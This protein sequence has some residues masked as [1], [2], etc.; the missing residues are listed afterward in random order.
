MIAS[1]DEVKEAV[2]REYSGSVAAV[3][4][5]PQTKCDT[6]H[7]DF[8]DGTE[9]FAKVGKPF[10]EDTYAAQIDI[11]SML[12]ERGISIPSVVPTATG[13]KYVSL[14]G[15]R[16]LEMHA[17]VPNGRPYNPTVE[18]V[19]QVARVMAEM[20]TAAD[21]LDREHSAMKIMSSHPYTGMPKGQALPDSAML[22][23]FESKLSDVPATLRPYVVAA[24]PLMR[25]SLVTEIPSR[26]WGI[27]HADLN[28][29]QTMFDKDTNQFK[30]LIDWEWMLFGPRARDISYS[31]STLTIGEKTSAESK[32]PISKPL[33]QSFID[34]YM[35]TR[36]N[37]SPEDLQAAFQHLGW[38][39][40]CRRTRWINQVL[41]G[42]SEERIAQLKEW[43]DPEP[44]ERARE[45]KDLL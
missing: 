8:K 18:D 1:V 34:T 42:V 27:I 33:V 36:S 44:F 17:W 16:F 9:R 31:L 45:L 40:T 4:K 39:A 32:S 22:D 26:D 7:V 6:F 30:A 10:H 19:T 21:S 38:D 23:Y 11:V 28:G 5:L 41:G 14:G 25:E 20:H 15:G 35:A 3:N 29:G 37:F 13:A 24:L 2:A 12:S 43:F